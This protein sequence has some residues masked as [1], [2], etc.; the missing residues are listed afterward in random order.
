MWCSCL[1]NSFRWGY[2]KGIDVRARQIGGNP[3]CC[4]RVLC[5]YARAYNMD[6]VRTVCNRVLICDATRVAVP[7]YLLICPCMWFKIYFFWY[8]PVYV[9]NDF[10]IGMDRMCFIICSLLIGSFDPSTVLLFRTYV[11]NCN[12]HIKLIP[13]NNSFHTIQ[14]NILFFLRTYVRTPYVFLKL[15]FLCLEAL[16]NNNGDEQNDVRLLL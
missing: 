13:P 11:K 8:V 7:V 10:G 4:T 16:P 6:I 3:C 1:C 2:K 5:M 12:M 14:V 15:S 9:C